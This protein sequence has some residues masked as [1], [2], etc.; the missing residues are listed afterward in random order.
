MLAASAPPPSLRSIGC[1]TLIAVGHATSRPSVSSAALLATTA[2][3]R[4]TSA[5][6][7]HRDRGHASQACGRLHQLTTTDDLDRAAASRRTAAVAPAHQ[8]TCPSVPAASWQLT[9]VAPPRATAVAAPPRYH[10]CSNTRARRRQQPSR[11]LITTDTVVGRSRDLS[12]AHRSDLWVLTSVSVPDSHSRVGF[13]RDQP[14]Q[15]AHEHMVEVGHLGFR[16]RAL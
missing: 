8:H 16:L 11:Q 14:R 7:A 5:P 9:A 13:L 1:G 6:P 12:V 4:T 2:G 3:G 10:Q 15:L